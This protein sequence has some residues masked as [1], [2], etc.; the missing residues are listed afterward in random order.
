MSWILG[1][2]VS[3]FIST[4]AYADFQPKMP[5][6]NP[7]EYKSP[8]RIWDIQVDAMKMTLYVNGALP[9]RCYGQ[10]FATL[11]QDE[12]HPNTLLLRLSSQKPTSPY[13]ISQEQPYSAVVNLP[14]V[15]QSSQ[16]EIEDKS[17]Y[18]IKTEGYEFSVQV[19]GSDLMSL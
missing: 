9:N 2:T 4:F 13:C 10:P 7:A 15:A 11:V 16:L 14:V 5:F 8:I 12:K 6:S 19:F 17:L 1:T 3:L 18:L